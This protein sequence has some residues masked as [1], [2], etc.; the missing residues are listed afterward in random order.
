M[1][2]WKIKGSKEKWESKNRKVGKNER[3]KRRKEEEKKDEG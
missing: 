1:I 2:L 3:M